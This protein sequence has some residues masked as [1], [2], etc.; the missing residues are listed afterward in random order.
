MFVKY[1]CH[2][3]FIVDDCYALFW[4]PNAYVD[5]LMHIFTPCLYFQCVFNSFQ[6][7]ITLLRALSV[8]LTILIELMIHTTSAIFRKAGI[9]LGYDLSSPIPSE[10]VVVVVW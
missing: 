3:R 9:V 1:I 7:V 6:C 2:F 4:T 8:A 10:E 5:I